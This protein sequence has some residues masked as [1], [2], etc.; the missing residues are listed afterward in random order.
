MRQSTRGPGKPKLTAHVDPCPARLHA[1]RL[2]V[3]HPL[4]EPGQPFVQR[5][6]TVTYWMPIAAPEA[7]EETGVVQPQTPSG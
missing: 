4:Q 7:V 2:R 5:T 3:E 6:E 1:A